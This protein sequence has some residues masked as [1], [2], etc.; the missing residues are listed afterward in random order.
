MLKDERSDEEGEYRKFQFTV[1][2]QYKICSIPDECRASWKNKTRRKTCRAW[3][4]YADPHHTRP[5]HCYL[6]E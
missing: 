5:P 3:V 1:R 4:S 6:D 2:Y